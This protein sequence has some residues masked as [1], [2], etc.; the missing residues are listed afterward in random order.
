MKNLSRAILPSALSL[1]ILA[2]AAVAA[3]EKVSGPGFDPGCFAP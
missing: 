1:A 2:S 3:P